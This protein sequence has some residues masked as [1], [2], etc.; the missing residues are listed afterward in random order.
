MEYLG[1]GEGPVKKGRKKAQRA[2]SGTISTGIEAMPRQ[3]AAVLPINK[4]PRTLWRC[5]PTTITSAG[6][7][8]AA[9]HKA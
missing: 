4:R 5:V 3:R 8:L 1:Y 2:D 7:S 6:I 9:R